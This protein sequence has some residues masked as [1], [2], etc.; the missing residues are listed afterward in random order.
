[1]ENLRCNKAR[2]GK[3]KMRW[4]PALQPENAGNAGDVA[5]HSN[6]DRR[7]FLSDFGSRRLFNGEMTDGRQLLA[8]YVEK[9]SEPA[10]RELV[11]RYIDLVYSTAFRLMDGDTHSAEDVAQIVF[12][13]LARMARTLCKEVLLG[14]WLHRHTCY[15]AANEMRSRC[16]RQFRERQAVEMNALDTRSE[17]NFSQLA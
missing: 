17:G 11:S 9:G 1:M 2:P 8:D 4:L 16:R 6:R 7:E 12:A 14:G 15:V 3:R 10:F 5:F 13:D